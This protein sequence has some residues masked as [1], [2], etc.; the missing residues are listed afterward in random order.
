MTSPT[1]R[2]CEH[3]ALFHRPRSRQPDAPG[4]TVRPREPAKRRA[5]RVRPAVMPKAPAPLRSAYGLSLVENDRVFYVEKG[6][7]IRKRDGAK[8]PNRVPIK[9]FS[10]AAVCG[11]QRN[12][13]IS[14]A[15]IFTV[16]NRSATAKDSRTGQRI[17]V[18]HAISEIRRICGPDAAAKAESA[19]R[20]ILP[21]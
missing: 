19:F 7:R 13:I 3:A 21:E 16:T 14:A 5:L 1:L 18:M 8:V 6:F 12:G 17:P 4:L 11:P 15:A 20:E 2:A 10:V 9:F